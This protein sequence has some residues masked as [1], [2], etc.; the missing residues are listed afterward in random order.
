MMAVVRKALC[1]SAENEVSFTSAHIQ[2]IV[3]NI[4]VTSL[5]GKGQSEESGTGKH[6]QIV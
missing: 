4:V 5:K 3:C 6:S 2:L 1:V